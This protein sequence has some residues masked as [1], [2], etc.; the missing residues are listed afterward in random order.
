MAVETIGRTL[1]SLIFIVCGIGNVVIVLEQPT[2][3][4]VDVLWGE[5]MSYLMDKHSALVHD[6]IYCNS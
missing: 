1:H 3:T 4:T 2:R 5:L 6:V